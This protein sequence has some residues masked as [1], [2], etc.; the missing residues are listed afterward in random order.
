MCINL[1]SGRVLCYYISA[2]L[3][4]YQPLCKVSYSVTNALPN[5][6]YNM[7]KF[8]SKS[9]PSL[10]LKIIFQPLLN[11]L[12]HMYVSVSGHQLLHVKLH[13]GF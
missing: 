6:L 5:M 13:S 4:L 7:D 9:E 2:H 10:F 3:F 12:T 8:D 1:R 11:N